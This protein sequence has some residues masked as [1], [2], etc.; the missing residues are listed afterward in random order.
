MMSLSYENIFF[1]FYFL[2]LLL[3]LRVETAAVNNSKENVSTDLDLM[4]FLRILFQ[5][6]GTVHFLMHIRHYFILLKKK[7][8]MKPIAFDF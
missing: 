3:W 4:H 7:Y 1:F 5:S 8:L 2:N 6:L